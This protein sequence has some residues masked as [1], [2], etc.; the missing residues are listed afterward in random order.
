MVL[1]DHLLKLRDER[2][3]VQLNLGEY[4]KV[5]KQLNNDER[6]TLKAK[7]FYERNKARFEA[8]PEE[9]LSKK[10]DILSV[11]MFSN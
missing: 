7:E 11:S 5:I 2:R 1:S 4:I 9:I 3:R 6:E 10:V 8:P